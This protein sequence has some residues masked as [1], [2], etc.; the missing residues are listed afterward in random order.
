MYSRCIVVH[1]ACILAKCDAKRI[2]P[3]LSRIV[4]AECIVNCHTGNVGWVGAHRKPT[5]HKI[6][7]EH[8]DK[9][10]DFPKRWRKS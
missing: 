2:Y 3:I 1:L 10:R 8:L 4:F 9:W 7:K 5:L 6:R